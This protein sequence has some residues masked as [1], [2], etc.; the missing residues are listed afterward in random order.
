[1]NELSWAARLWAVDLRS[2]ALLRIA[3]GFI[4]LLDLAIRATDLRAH[5]T[6][7]GVAPRSSVLELDAHPGYWSLHFLNGTWTFQALLFGFAAVAATCMLVGYRT[8]WATLISWAMLISLHSRNIMVLDGGDIYLRCVFFWCLFLPWGARWSVDSCRPGAE[9]EQDH[10]YFGAGVLGYVLQLS[11]IY[12]VAVALKTGDPWRVDGSAVYYTLMVD[13]LTTPL[14]PLLLAQPAIMRFLT[15]ATLGFELLG[16]FLYWLPGR[17]R[18]LGILSFMGMHL[19]FAAFMHLGVFGWVAVCSNLGLLPAEFWDRFERTSLFGWLRKGAARVGKQWAWPSQD[20]PRACALPADSWLVSA[21][22]LYV[23]LWN[24]TT[25]PGLKLPFR[26]PEA[27][28]RILRVDQ[29]WSMFAP[30]PLTGDGWYVIEAD[31]MD[32]QKIDLF[33]GGAPVNWEKPRRVAAM[34]VNA[35]WRKYMM[36]ICQADLQDWRQYYGRYLTRN[37]NS[38]HKGNQRISGFRI[39]FMLE[40]TLPN[41]TTAPVRKLTLWSHRCF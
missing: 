17:F 29:K 38:T 19:G 16:P 5:Y 23:V 4:L 36:N 28:G 7:M 20:D 22:A 33:R 40:E 6:D 30:R 32:G 9:P 14:A 35:R 8:R 13:Q 15:Y 3:Y 21:A 31:R 1:M 24:L 12:W 34:Y 41:G 18:M 26:V 37:W 25:I 10:R 39:Y 27:P 2:L 11:L